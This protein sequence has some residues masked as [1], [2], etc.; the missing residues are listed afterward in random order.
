[1]NSPLDVIVDENNKSLIISDYGTRRVVQWS[2][3][4]SNDDKQI[5]IE[6]IE[7]FG[8]MMNR[9]G[10]LFVSDYANHVV[11]RWRKGEIGNLILSLL[12]IFHVVYFLV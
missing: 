4:N 2:L 5:L 3:E 1:M 10:D 8:L 11:K 9:N 12:L 6:N 7:C